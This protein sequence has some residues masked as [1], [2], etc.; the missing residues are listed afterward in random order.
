MSKFDKLYKTYESSIINEADVAQQQPDVGVNSDQP[1]IPGPTEQ[2]QQAEPT[3]DLTSEGKKFLVDLALKSLA[4]DPNKIT[5]TDKNIFT[6]QVT[7]ENANEMLQK[8]QTLVD[9]YG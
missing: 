6:T 4:I 2:P 3:T 1:Q 7:K 9:L 8:I 5:T